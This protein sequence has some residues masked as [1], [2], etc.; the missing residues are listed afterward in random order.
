MEVSAVVGTTGVLPC[1]VDD[2]G[3]QQVGIFNNYVFSSLGIKILSEIFY[4]RVLEKVA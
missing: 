4:F 3:T 2:I 1:S